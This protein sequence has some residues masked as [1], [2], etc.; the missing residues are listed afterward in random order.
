M[1]IYIYIPTF[2]YTYIYIY[3]YVYSYKYIYKYIHTI[4]IYMMFMVFFLAYCSG[5]FRQGL[6]RDPVQLCPTGYQTWPPVV[7]VPFMGRFTQL[8]WVLCLSQVLRPMAQK[9]DFIILHIHIPSGDSSG[10][11]SVDSSGVSPD[12]F[13][14]HRQTDTTYLR[15]W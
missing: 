7:N 1:Y 15:S 2:I 9:P 4:Y 10:D 6:A 8:C 14:H 5:D 12:A 11:S 13:L 3:I